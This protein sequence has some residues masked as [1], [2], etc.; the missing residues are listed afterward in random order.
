MGLYTSPHL[1]S[2]T[3][4][5]K[6]DGQEIAEEDV[7][8]FVAK[9]RDFL[10]EIQPSFFEMTVGMA[11]W[12]FA[13]RKVDVAVVEV[14]MGGRLDSTN[15]I[16]PK[17]SVI[18]NIGW[19]HMQYLGNTLTE[20][21][22]EKAGIIKHEVP[23]VI[24]QKQDEIAEVFLNKAKEKGAPIYFADEEFDVN[25]SFNSRSDLRNYTVRKGAFSYSVSLD[26]LGNYQQKNLPGVLKSLEILRDLCYN[27]KDSHL[28][29]GLAQIARLT[30]LKGRW[31]VLSRSPLT[32]CDTGHNEDGMRM[33]M[34][35]IENTQHEN[36]L[37]VLGMVNDKDIQK[38]LSL[39]P[40]TAYYYFCQAN[41]PRAM[42]AAT[43][44]EQASVMGLEGEIEKDVNAAIEKAK[45]KAGPEDM[46]FIGGST[47]VVA[48]IKD[49]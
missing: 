40:K 25:S 41:I 27:I 37:V 28:K 29:S 44:S 43:L 46:I 3:E 9:N 32:V 16:Q 22:G 2:F 35:Q 31:Q 10:K 36:L 48:E 23:V 8:D 45:K 21:A 26:L 17:L 47:F 42:E 12:Y 18:T 33:L 24:S 7:V 6:V 1:K 5:I 34:E 49:L 39:L 14:G 11:F 30:G 19:D 13:Q 4:R 38:V 20:I 15:V